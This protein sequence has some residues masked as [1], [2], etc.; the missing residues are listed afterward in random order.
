MKAIIFPGQGSQSKGMGD[1]L[2]DKYDEL[3]SKASEILGYS[4]KK[5]CLEDPDNQ[6]A[7]T[8]YTQPALFVI[9]ALMWLET[10]ESLDKMPEYLAGHS[11]GEYNALFAA[12]AFDFEIGLKL[13]KKRGEL[14][15]LSKG[16][17]MAAVIGLDENKINTIISENNLN[18]LYIANY[19]STAQI[20][21]S[22]KDSEIIEAEPFFKASDAKM[23]VKLKVS[24][25]FHTRFMEVASVEFSRY[26]NDIK[27][28]EIKIPVISN[29]TA[30][31]YSSN[32]IS[33][34]LCQQL[35]SPVQ[36]TDS[37]RYLMGKKVDKF[38]EVGPGKVLTGLI[39][40]IKKEA[41]PLID[42]EDE[43]TEEPTFK[44][45]TS[46]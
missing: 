9:N 15:S 1:Q 17:G 12:E 35:T 27:F 26:I 41:T 23:Y 40:R 10:K 18:N 22:G 20:V 45:K 8:Q 31:P 5:L 44:K 25:A 30:R 24:G 42:N 4:I 32:K 7:Q 21:I 46:K 2:F 11:L 3:T 38:Q 28:N 14:M 6:L 34:L 43:N 16:G 13:V 37:I 19:N 36:W 33:E 39:R 29:V